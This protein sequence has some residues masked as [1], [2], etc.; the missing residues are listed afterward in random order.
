[1]KSFTIATLS[2]L[3]LVG[4]GMVIGAKLQNGSVASVNVRPLFET[5][6][7]QPLVLNP[8]NEG[9]MITS[10]DGQTLLLKGDAD[11][12]VLIPKGTLFSSSCLSFK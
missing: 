10:E 7:N 9:C 1:M 6:N 11:G 2:A 5:L 12:R 4:S 8:A 3:A